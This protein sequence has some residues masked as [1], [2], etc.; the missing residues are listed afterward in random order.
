[1]T[2]TT[3]RS[4]RAPP[5]FCA[6]MAPRAS[7]SRRYGRWPARPRPEVGFPAL[8]DR[9]V[10]PEPGLGYAFRLLPFHRD[11]RIE[12]SQLVGCELRAHAVEQCLEIGRCPVQEIG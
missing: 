4:R 6:R 2:S 8:L 7:W 5:V 11:L 12:L 10:G 1:R 3:R 9:P